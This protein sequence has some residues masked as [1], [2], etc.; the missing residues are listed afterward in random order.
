MSLAAV[1]KR[2]IQA[3]VTNRMP[4]DPE[5]QVVLIATADPEIYSGLSEL[6]QS[7]SLNAVWVKGVEAAKRVL[8]SEKIVACLCGFWL[9]D[10]T[11][12]ELIRHL[13]R[14]RRRIPAIIVSAPDCPGE[15]RDYLA[16]AKIG[17]LD[18]L[19]H[20]YKKS[21]LIK[22]LSLVLQG[23]SATVNPQEHVNVPGTA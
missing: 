6:F 10:G 20:P 12:R 23:E 14:G 7:F 16:A 2:P 8:I 3:A 21:D 13:R 22:M 19:S 11:Y 18:F 1:L 9:Q 17:A 5:R 15:Y 4:A